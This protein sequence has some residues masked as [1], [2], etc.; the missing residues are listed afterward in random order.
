MDWGYVAGY[1][2]G[3][4]SVRFKAAPSRPDY[5]LVGLEW[6][7]T[8]LGSL[9]AMRDF[10]GCGRIQE[11]A[12]GRNKPV[13]HLQIQRVEDVLRVGEQML[14]HLIIKGD[15]LAEMMAWARENRKALPETWGVLAAAGVEEITRLYHEEG[16]T[17]K[18][19]AAKFGVGAGAVATFFLRNG[20]R[21]RR[22]GPKEGA[23]GVLAQF[24]HERLQQMYEDGMTMA[25]IAEQLGVR[26][27]T[28]YMHFYV[29]GVRVD[30][31]SREIRRKRAARKGNA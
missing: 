1:F 14:P 20:I 30:S 19:I 26:A 3:E 21:G 8:H 12:Q 17:Q 6:A 5:I 13:Y 15:K 18:E 10:M 24:G 7:N 11:S 9:E 2:D 23:Y 4:G 29:R 22:R 31:P 25:E 28:V 16:L 27:H